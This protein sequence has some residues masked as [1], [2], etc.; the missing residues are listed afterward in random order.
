MRKKGD[1]TWEMVR[2]MM[3][4][5]LKAQIT[6]NAMAL[7]KGVKKRNPKALLSHEQAMEAVTALYFVLLP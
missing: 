1:R 3:P 6:Y 7:R 2:E 5:E 4:D